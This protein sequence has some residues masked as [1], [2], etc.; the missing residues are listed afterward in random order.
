ML[1]RIRNRRPGFTLIELLVVI[2]IIATLVSLLL[3]AVQRAR[4]AANR[5]SC[6]NNLK[7]LGLAMH[8][9]HDSFKSFP[10]GWVDQVG[11]G[12][13]NWGWATY[14]LPQMEQGN[15]Y[16]SLN[17]G[18]VNMMQA[19]NDATML[20][21]MRTPLSLYRCPS[22][23]APNVNTLHTM[24]GPAGTEQLT[25]SNYI[26]S[27]GGLDYGFGTNANGSPVQLTGVFGQNS[28]VEIKDITDGTS[29][30]IAV[31]ERSWVQATQP[32]GNAQCNAAV[33]FGISG[34]NG[35][36][37]NRA[38]GNGFFGIN[39]TGSFGGAG[40]GDSCSHAFNSLHDGGTQFL[41]ADGS[42]HFLSENLQRDQQGQGGSFVYQNLLNR[43]DGFVV[44][45]Y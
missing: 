5:S 2:A 38:L 21:L 3:P 43:A 27:T 22:D 42:V 45:E 12:G 9:Y 11:P 10:P 37:P 6:Q 32:S 24:A 16:K 4:E 20:P 23:T 33:L 29:N 15:L 40:S 44:G 1:R 30:T 18:N 28:S 17:V 35:Y 41:F 25:T 39:Q 31:G 7:Q 36:L 19:M 13:S 26:G 34:G 8:N 14:L